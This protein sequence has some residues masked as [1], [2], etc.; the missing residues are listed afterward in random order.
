M[1]LNKKKYEVTC[2]MCKSK[3]FEESWEED[4]RD[5]NG[6][7]YG[8]YTYHSGPDICPYCNEDVKKAY[9]ILLEN[10]RLEQIQKEE[11]AKIYDR[12]IDKWLVFTRFDR[13]GK[14]YIYTSYYEPKLG[15]YTYKGSNTIALIEVV[16]CEKFNIK[17]VDKY[18]IL[19]TKSIDMFDGKSITKEEIAKLLIPR[20]ENQ[21]LWAWNSIEDDDIE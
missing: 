14:E 3:Y 7:H 5:Y 18:P 4:G 19:K 11:E 1:I 15:F 9:P 2:K 21:F 10:E 20:L 13:H 8:S 17:N 6:H 16:R 12:Y